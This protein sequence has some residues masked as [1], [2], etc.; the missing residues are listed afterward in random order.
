MISCLEELYLAQSWKT[1]SPTQ[2]KF[3]S[4]TPTILHTSSV[5]KMHIII[6]LETIMIRTPQPFCKGYTSYVRTGSSLILNG[7]TIWIGGTILI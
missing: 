2:L 3:N 7:S 6:Q 1:S 4:L 5:G